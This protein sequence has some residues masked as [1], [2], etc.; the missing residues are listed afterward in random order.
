VRCRHQTKN[1]IQR[2]S[3]SSRFRGA[4]LLLRHLE[5]HS[6]PSPSSYAGLYSARHDHHALVLLGCHI[7]PLASRFHRAPTIHPHESMHLLRYE[8]DC[9]LTIASFEDNAIPRYAILSHTWGPDAEEV[10]FADLA[11]GG[12]KHKSGYNKIRFCGDQAQQDGLQYFWVDTCCI[13]KSDKAELSLA[14]QSMFRW[15]QNAT[16]CYVYLSDVSTR[17]RK[18]GDLPTEFT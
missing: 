12:G 13:D 16:K 8:D 7:E 3:L 2:V 18:A 17:K 14:I 9:R 5:L 6:Y 4:V 11:E 1:T 15:Y 10:T